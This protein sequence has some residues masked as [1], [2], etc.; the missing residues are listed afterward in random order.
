[1]DKQAVVLEKG[2]VSTPLDGFDSFRTEVITLYKHYQDQIDGIAFSLPGVIDSEQGYN[3]A[4]LGAG[5]QTGWTGVVAKTILLFG[6][7]DSKRA[8]QMGSKAAF[9]PGSRKE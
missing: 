3:G 7:M 8:L 9:I 1:M 6:Y 2:Q 5:H 4:G